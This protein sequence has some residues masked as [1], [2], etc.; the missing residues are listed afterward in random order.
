MLQDFFCSNHGCFGWWQR[1][2][3]A[4]TESEWNLNRTSHVR[5]T[6]GLERQIR[7]KSWSF[8]C[9]SLLSLELGWFD[10]MDR[11]RTIPTHHHPGQYRNTVGAGPGG[12]E[13]HISDTP[14][15][16]PQPRGIQKGSR[17]EASS[18][19]VQL[20]KA[21]APNYHETPLIHKQI[22][23]PPFS[24]LVE[25]CRG[26]FLLDTVSLRSRPARGSHKADNHASMVASYNLSIMIDPISPSWPICI[27]ASCGVSVL[28]T[29][30]P[31]VDGD[32]SSAD[33]IA[34]ELLFSLGIS[35]LSTLLDRSGAGKVW[36]GCGCICLPECSYSSP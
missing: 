34:H 10:E 23:L 30:P 1:K 18:G 36:M 16:Q 4:V 26:S 29:Q 8:Y 20:A 21:S 25:P 27:L 33:F 28:L 12:Q 6:P 19:D 32:Y 5:I 17:H 35:R 15:V 24:K 7:I 9:F 14:A 13:S 22:V 31:G 2:R 11:K 3:R